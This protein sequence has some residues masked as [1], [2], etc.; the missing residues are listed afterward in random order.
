MT[1]R[2]RPS[3]LRVFVEWSTD[4]VEEPYDIG[5]VNLDELYPQA[6]Q[7]GS[8]VLSAALRRLADDIDEAYEGVQAG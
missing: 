1:T 4:T 5:T 3:E 8:R 2:T 7:H 6:D